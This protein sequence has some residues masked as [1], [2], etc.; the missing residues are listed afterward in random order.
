M[1]CKHCGTESADKF[2]PHCGRPLIELSGATPPLREKPAER[3]KKEVEPQP[4]EKR[5]EEK[6]SRKKPYRLRFSHIFFP[7]LTFFLHWYTFLP[8]F[9]RAWLPSFLQPMRQGTR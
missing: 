8:T 2:C 4:E 5:A 9:M 3:E 1:I 7:V 6:R